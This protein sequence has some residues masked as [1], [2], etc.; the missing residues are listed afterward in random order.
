[1]GNISSCILDYREPLVLKT[2]SSGNAA[3]ARNWFY[4]TAQLNKDSFLAGK[5]GIAPLPAE[6]GTGVGALG[7]WGLPSVRSQI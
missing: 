7:G 4:Q 5:S 3:F 2:F 1:M 6:N